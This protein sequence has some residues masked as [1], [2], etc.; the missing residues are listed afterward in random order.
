MCIPANSLEL[1]RSHLFDKHCNHG[2]C[3]IS[4]HCFPERHPEAQITG[5]FCLKHHHHADVEFLSGLCRRSDPRGHLLLDA[6]P[7][8]GLVDR[9]IAILTRRS[10]KLGVGDSDPGAL[11]RASYRPGTFDRAYHLSRTGVDF[12]DAPIHDLGD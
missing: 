7:D 10:H 5:L 11:D 8:L 3:A 1:E 2:D 9:R 12:G 6:C 4:I